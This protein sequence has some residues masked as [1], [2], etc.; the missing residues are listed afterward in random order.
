[1][2]TLTQ[3][4]HEKVFA[5]LYRLSRIRIPAFSSIIIVILTKFLLKLLVLPVAVIFVLLADIRRERIM[6]SNSLVSRTIAHTDH[7]HTYTVKP[8]EITYFNICTYMSD[9]RTY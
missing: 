1:M 3:M 8:I 9:T 2:H 4:T 6:Y 7:T 5:L